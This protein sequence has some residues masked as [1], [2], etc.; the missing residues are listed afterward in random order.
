MFENGPYHCPMLDIADVPHG[1]IALRTDQRVHF[2][3]FLDKPRLIPASCLNIPLR[4]ENA[5]D[6][7]VVAILLPF[8]LREIRRNAGL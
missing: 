5:G 7:V 8:S 4:F 2:I 1:T 6:D 3:Y